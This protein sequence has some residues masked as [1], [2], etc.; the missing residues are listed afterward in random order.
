MIEF[1]KKVLDLS[2]NIN[3]DILRI[4]GGDSINL[5]SQIDPISGVD[6]DKIYLALKEVSESLA[7]SYAQVKSDIK[8]ENR[9]SWAGTAHEI[10]EILATLLRT[11]APDNVVTIQP[12]YIQDPG[13]KGPTQNQRVIYILQQ[14]KAGSKQT[15]VVEKVAGL[16]DR[17]SDL[18]RSTYSRACDAAH[19][20]KAH[21]EVVRILKY[22]EA[23]AY[24]L[25][26]L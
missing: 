16:D 12:W 3:S 18:V 24:D 5:D 6:E 14:Q 25:L 20:L 10:R 1:Y 7:N 15:E 26:D 13:I 17:I 8:A 9:I 4:A 11:L 22:F 19:R 2:R 21:Q 23:F